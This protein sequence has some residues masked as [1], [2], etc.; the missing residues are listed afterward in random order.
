[1]LKKGVKSKEQHDL[2]WALIQDYN[3]I[4]YVD[5]DA[6]KFSVLYANNVV[7]QDVKKPGF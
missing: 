6:D 2:F 4:Y 5:L 3:A 1:M 7:N